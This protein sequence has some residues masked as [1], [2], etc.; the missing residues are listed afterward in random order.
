MRPRGGG[1]FFSIPS[2]AGVAARDLRALTPVMAM[3]G[4]LRCASRMASYALSPCRHSGAATPPRLS[5]VSAGVPRG[6][7]SRIWQWPQ[8]PLALQWRP[9]SRLCGSRWIHSRDLR[10][11]PSG[12][13]FRRWPQLWRPYGLTGKGTS[14]QLTME[15]R[16]AGAYAEGPWR[17]TTCPQLAGLVAH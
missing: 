2:V 16:G 17:N 3:S 1:M 8:M 4:Q 12:K 15:V 7:Q 5:P 10:L 14:W 11:S 9:A 6:S 13:H